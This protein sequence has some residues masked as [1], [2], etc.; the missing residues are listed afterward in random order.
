MKIDNF[1]FW[2]IVSFLLGATI[3]SFFTEKDVI[4]RWEDKAIEA[5]AAYYHPTTGEFT[6][7]E[8]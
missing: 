4:K 7:R 5:G 6:W 3:S 8:E 1:V 2:L